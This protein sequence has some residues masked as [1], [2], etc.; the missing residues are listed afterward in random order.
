MK[1]CHKGKNKKCNCSGSPAFK[2]QKVGCPSNQQWC[3]TITIQKIS[4]I[5]KLI[6]KI[7]QNWVSST[8]RPWPFLTMPT[9]KSLNQHLGLLNLCQHAKTQFIPSVHSSDTVSFRVLSPNWPHPFL[10]M[11]SPEFFNHLLVCVNL[12]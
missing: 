5:H 9:Q 4:S 2:N 10:T 3:I 11:L 1:Y 8:K 12:C 7:Q 6:L